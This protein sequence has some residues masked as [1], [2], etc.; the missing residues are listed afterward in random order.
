[1]KNSEKVVIRKARPD[2]IP[3]VLEMIK[4]LAEY[5]KLLEKV[6]ATEESLKDSIFGNEQIVEVWLAEVDDI[7]A[8]HVFF[9]RN[10]STFLAKPGLYIE[11]IYVKPQFRN[12]GFG[13]KLLLKVVE[14]AHKN[15]YGRVEWSVLDW[16]K[17]AIKFYEKL[18]A[19]A[20]NGW[21]VFRLT[22]NEIERL[23]KDY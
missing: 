16:N 20:M 3:L 9:F 13:K 12:K 18:G 15:N 8:G 17:S 14:I 1:M 5:E 6:V 21:S 11:D 19:V 2:D 7:V 22:S 4:E 23:T 10:F